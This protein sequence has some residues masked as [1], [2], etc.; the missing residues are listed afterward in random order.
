MEKAK[1]YWDSLSIK[2]KDHF[3]KDHKS[4]I[5][6]SSWLSW[7]GKDF[8]SLPDNAKK[9]ISKHVEEGLYK[10]GGS[11]TEFLE[12]A[13]KSA[14][15]AGKSVKQSAE[16]LSKTAKSKYSETKKAVNEKVKDQKRKIALDVLDET[17]D[18]VKD[19]KYKMTLKGAEQIIK[20]KYA[21][22][23]TLESM[24]KQLPILELQNV[25]GYKAYYDAKK[26]LE[27]ANKEHDN[28]FQSKKVIDNYSQLLLQAK[29][30][31]KNNLQKHLGEKMALG[32][33]IDNERLMMD[34]KDIK[35][36]YPKAKVSYTFAKDKS[37]KGYVITA[38]EN[39]KVVYSSYKMALGG[40]VGNDQ[41]NVVFSRQDVFQKAKDFYENESA[42]YPSDVN[43]EFRTFVFDIENGEDA[44]TEYYLDQELQG[45]DLDGYYFEIADKMAT[46]GGVGNFSFSDEE[47]SKN[48]LDKIK[49]AKPGD[50]VNVKLKWMPNK[51]VSVKVLTS[52]KQ[53]N[54]DLYEEVY[55]AY[56]NYDG[57]LE[58]ISLDYSEKTAFI[59]GDWD[60]EINNLEILK[61]AKKYNLK[62]HLMKDGGMMATGG[63]VGKINVD[64]LKRAEKLLGAKK[65]REINAMS[66]NELED[67]LLY[68][69][70]TL[71]MIEES[72]SFQYDRQS[73]LDAI[74]I[75]VSAKLNKMAK[76]SNIKKVDLFE[77]YE[78]I[79]NNIQE[80]LDKYEQDFQDGNY[81][82][83]A[84][85][86]KEVEQ[87]GYTFEYY[88]DGQAYALRPIGVKVEELEGYE[89]YAKG[90]HFENENREMVLNN[91]KQ[92]AHHT[93]ELQDA[94]KG[95]KVP[96][97]VVAKVNRSASDL[98]DATHY[99]EGQ[100][101]QYA[102]GSNV[103]RK[104]ITLEE[105]YNALKN[106]PN[107]KKVELRDSKY[108]STGK[109]IYILSKLV[110]P[111]EDDLN[112]GSID[113]FIIAYFGEE[114]TIIYL[115]NGYDQE[116]KTI[117]EIIDFT[118]ANEV[119]DTIKEPRVY[120]SVE[121]DSSE[122]QDYE[123]ETR[124]EAFSFAR[125]KEK[126]GYTVT[127]VS[128][129]IENFATRSYN[130]EA[131]LLDAFNTY[132]FN[133]R[134][135]SGNT[136][137]SSGGSWIINPNPFKWRKGSNVS[138]NWTNM[139]SPDEVEFACSVMNRIVKPGAYIDN[140][141][142][143]HSNK[144]ELAKAINSNM[145]IFSDEGKKLALSLIS[146][147]N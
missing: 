52:F 38:K 122:D 130:R 73:F 74:K 11:F 4:E 65:V 32:G 35:L 88:L 146:K 49:N 133:L 45:T 138:S 3:L 107:F 132:S 15:K 135:S 119:V 86:L 12:K 18:K 144:Y 93:K 85:A 145:S 147:L 34:L 43:D 109:E 128:K 81:E 95:K 67:E 140:E 68:A 50:I 113:E 111:P 66:M 136:G 112:Q 78:L 28:T 87:E 103:K 92:I 30:T 84:N 36:K 6:R 106:S 129:Y 57:N 80:I 96:A 110:A 117:D 116:V 100:S 48:E 19:N 58:V 137:R 59:G 91:N 90:G 13:K 99:M 1:T 55:I 23:G 24:E 75:V 64:D 77:H 114:L 105:I 27:K 101:E 124:S 7:L 33:G 115:P 62:H 76:G 9:V 98:S 120:Y 72:G 104:K 82:G 123:F 69:K 118:R 25:N 21:K 131:D 141:N 16:S 39:G 143:K 127:D 42:F 126:E 71:E 102:K 83:L 44:I 31:Y 89:K 54:P 63:G 40:G 142:L 41:L 8:D 29:E 10:S 60:D 56:C 134:L 61:I 121:L 125:K 97:W 17:K 51:K 14:V 79:P 46:G 139:L 22:G 47:M 94:V 53:I 26:T 108:T 37:G 5:K 2:Q 20:E 70:N